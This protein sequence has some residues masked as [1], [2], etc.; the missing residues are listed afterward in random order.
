MEGPNNPDSVSMGMIPRAV[1]QIFATAEKLKE[2]GWV[3]TMEGQ[4]VE[5]YNETVHDLLG[6]GDLNKKHDIKHVA[7]NK[8]I[9]TDVKTGKYTY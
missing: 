1:Q 4:F 6:N 5:I 9:I 3:Y 8:T 2:K 7:G